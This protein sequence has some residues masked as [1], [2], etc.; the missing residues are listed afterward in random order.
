MP[1]IDADILARE[2]VT[3]GSRGWQ[4]VIDHFGRDLIGA[5][6]ALDRRALG[7]RIF[8]NAK[9]RQA[10]EA[11]IHPEVYG[12]ILEWFERL[13]A[14]TTVGVA[15]IPL[16]FE[17]GHEG[18]FDVVVVAACDPAIQLERLIARDG[19]TQA[20]A[21][22]RLAA[23]WPIAEKTARADIVIWTNGPKS[24]TDQQIDRMYERLIQMAQ[25]QQ[26]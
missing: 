24:E 5:D 21:E 13:P 11:I 17:S 9:E 10:L 25:S 18:D 19:I 7:A 3:P 20:E 26:A 22:Q 12:A 2:A 14:D 6:G 8:A 16:L 4:A 23:Q 1:T 15:D